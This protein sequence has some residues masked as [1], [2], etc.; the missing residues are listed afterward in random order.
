[1][2]YKYSAEEKQIIYNYILR[3]YGQVDH[4]IF[5]S[6]EHI[7]VPIEYDILVIKKQNLQILMTFGLGAFK[8]HNHEENTQERAEIFLELPVD[9]DFNKHENMWPVHFLINIVK[10]SYSNHLTLK[11]L[12]TFINPSCFNKSNKIAGFLDLSW[13]G[14]NSLECKI[15]NDFFVSFY[16][17][18][19]IDDEELFYAKT[20]GIRA[21]SKFFDDGKSRIVDL[22]RKSFVK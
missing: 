15:N 18:L 16:Q 17:I 19:I 20:N 12:Q 1:M 5:L 22:N 2:N 21:L 3:E 7:R 11:W 8:S 13:Y 4:I 10:Y 9:W 14:E 6:N